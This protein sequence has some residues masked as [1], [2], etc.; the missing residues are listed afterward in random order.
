MSNKNFIKLGEELS[1]GS[2]S[3]QTIES[4]FS[5]PSIDE[6]FKKFAGDLRRITPKADDFLYFSAVMLH[7]AEAAL[8]NADGT[9]RVTAKGEPIEAHWDK[10]GDSWKWVCNDN[11]VRPY[12]NSNGD[13]FPESELLKAHSK[14]QGRPLC[15]DHKSSSVDAIRGKILDTYYDRQYKRVI[16]LCALDKVSYPELARGVTSGYK[17][18]VSMGTSV[19]TAICTDCGT[20]AKTEADFCNHMRNRTCYGEINIGLNPIEL[21]IVVN[22]ADPQAKIR[23]IIAAAR[24]VQE[25]ITQEEKEI[26]NSTNLVADHLSKMSRLEDASKKLVEIK[27][28]LEN[29]ADSIS[30]DAPYGQSSGR[31]ETP[32]DEINQNETELNLPERL[33]SVNNDASI[34]EVN[35]LIASLSDR[36]QKMEKFLSNNKEETN[37]AK[38]TSMNKE[39]YYQGG[40]GV[41]EPTPGQKKYPVDPKNEK[42]RSEDKHMVGEGPF[43]GVGNVDGLHPSPDS[44][45]Q[46]DELERKKML[47]RAEQEERAIRRSAALKSAKEKLGYFQGGG[48]VNEPTPG[49]QKYPVDGLQ[50]KLREKED[51]QMVGQKP[52]PGVGDVEG[53][54][55]SPLSADQKDE[56]ARK[57]L[58]QRASLKAKFVR[59]AN[60]DGTDNLGD[61]AWQVYAKD[62]SGEK[63]IFTASVDDIT[64]GR[65]DA[66]FDV[67]ATKDFGSKMLEKIRTVG[68]TKAASVF[69]K[70]QALSGPAA[71]PGLPADQGGAGAVPAMPDMGAPGGGPVD[72]PANDGSKPEDEGG[73]GDPKETAMKL[74]EKVR[75]LSSDLLEAVR[76]LTGE[77]AQMGDMEEGLESMPKA[78]S[79]ILTP[80]YSM[81][82]NLHGALLAGAKKDLADLKDHAEEL[83]LVASVVG[84]DTNM[85]KDYINS[86]VQE[87]FSD[88]NESIQDAL[89]VKEAFRE[90]ARGTAGLMK[91]AAEVQSNLVATAED[92]M[93]DARKAK[94]KSTEPSK[95][96]KEDEKEA[97]ESAKEEEKEDE[98]DADD[99]FGFDFL[100]DSVSPHGEEA[101]ALPEM[102]LNVGE[103]DA[104]L[105]HD[106]V[107]HDD[108]DALAD[109]ELS[110]DDI[111]D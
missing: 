58:L 23:T 85:D 66:L 4:V 47:A 81:R 7:S 82:K 99:N 74:S 92:D 49:K 83:E 14:W 36:I 68:L 102:D 41:N 59:V 32:S 34:S 15:I 46:K 39:A 95:S 50:D 60:T 87:S 31:L 9:M 91:R 18:S 62:E 38:D 53:L 26:K 76:S 70:A 88:A 16:G 106:L 40:G 79:E 93:N 96:E 43:P 65:S 33:A 51:K 30:K 89:G 8:V 13:I 45:D 80:L 24:E 63:L 77:Q 37:M 71:T 10:K 75:D 104:D 109:E 100:S 86:V 54:H 20:A 94:K 110:V 5:D 21:S 97:K 107:G 52:F 72:A 25:K 78:A 48:G 103:E 22:G 105:D 42:L 35:V 27:E 56:L 61:S 57:K 67:V 1:I 2:N 73:K 55:P 29:E 6:R 84:S 101:D 19:E 69:K 98:S 28:M 111:N 108:K 44:A 64:G 17:T 90:Y 11:N 12:R 3:I